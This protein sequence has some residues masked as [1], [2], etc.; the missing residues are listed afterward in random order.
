M[1]E[2]Y[3]LEGHKAVEADLMTW[4]RWF[5]TSSRADRIV[6]RTELAECTVSTVFIGL[7]HNLGDGPPHIFETLVLGG[8]LA[9]EMERY[10]TWEQAEAGHE[11]MVGRVRE[12]LS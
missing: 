1:S 3:I 12:T 9:D 2:H 5:E 10:S 7:D 4:A 11:V 8:K 6:A